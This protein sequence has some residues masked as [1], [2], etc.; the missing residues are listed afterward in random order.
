MVGLS[1]YLLTGD[2]RNSFFKDSLKKYGEEEFKDYY[3]KIHRALDQ[4][5]P[6]RHYNI[7]KDVPADK[8]ELF[9][10]ICQDY[11][12]A[13]PKYDFDLEITRIHHYYNE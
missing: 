9:V 7:L 12:F 2:N 11:T 10:Q 1:Q 13:N 6:G 4:L 5:K 3:L 8:Q